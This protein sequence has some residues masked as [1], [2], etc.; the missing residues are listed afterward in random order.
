M[1]T[2]ECSREPDAREISTGGGSEDAPSPDMTS[3]IPT[4]VVH[5]GD[6]SSA[7]GRPRSRLG[8]LL[9]I[10]SR[11]YGHS[12][13]ASVP[14]LRSPSPAI[15]RPSSSKRSSSALGRLSSVFHRDKNSQSPTL[16]DASSASSSRTKK[17]LSAQNMDDALTLAQ[18]VVKGLGACASIIPNT[19]GLDIVISSLGKVLEGVSEAR[20]SAKEV[21]RIADCVCQLAENVQAAYRQ[22]RDRNMSMSSTEGSENVFVEGSSVNAV[23]ISTTVTA[24]RASQKSDSA[25]ALREAISHLAGRTMNEIS[26][27]ASAITKSKMIVQVF[28]SKQNAS[29]LSSIRKKIDNACTNFQTCAIVR[30]E[31]T[32]NSIDLMTKKTSLR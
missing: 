14:A 22:A 23:E 4:I 6:S 17:L 20:D 27:E 16:T 15:D 32:I 31:T 2:V 12:E 5:P 25:D 10:R 13:T 26:E 21:K 24:R 7:R 11:S 29:K 18:D 28:R 19:P 30:I 1:D 3:S 8:G 9:H